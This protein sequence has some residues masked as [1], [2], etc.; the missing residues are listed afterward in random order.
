MGV[1]LS[2]LLDDAGHPLGDDAEIAPYPQGADD[3]A[4]ELG[5]SAVQPFLQLDDLSENVVNTP[6]VFW[7]DH[8]LL[9]AQ[10][11]GKANLLLQGADDVTDAGLSVVQPLGGGGQTAAAD[12]L[13]EGVVAD[14]LQKA[15]PLSRK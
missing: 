12:G 1:T 6:A 14:G 15:G 4:I 2:E 13:D 9:G 8:P 7:G 5:H 3:H 10:Q 11:Q